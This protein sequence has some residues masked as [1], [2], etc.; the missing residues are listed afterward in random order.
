VNNKTVG[1]MVGNS[2]ENPAMYNLS[3]EK[4][5]FSASRRWDRPISALV[6]HPEAPEWPARVP[7]D[8]EAKS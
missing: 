2:D 5:A 4:E 8:T 6:V 3:Q 1:W 7:V